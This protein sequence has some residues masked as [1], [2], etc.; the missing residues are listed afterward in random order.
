MGM[1]VRLSLCAKPARTKAR[2][3]AKGTH[4]RAITHTNTNTNITARTL[5]RASTPSW[6]RTRSIYNHAIASEPNQQGVSTR[7]SQLTGGACGGDGSRCAIDK[8]PHGVNHRWRKKAHVWLAALH[9]TKAQA[10]TR[11]T[12]ERAADEKFYTTHRCRLR[13]DTT[14]RSSST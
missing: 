14:A 13:C 9:E 8:A 5:G 6:I 10:R 4:A 3:A 2:C 11:E 7:G 1:H 12:V